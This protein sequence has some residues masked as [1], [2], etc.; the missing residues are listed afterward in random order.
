MPT[1]PTDSLRNVVLL[2]HSGAG[3]TMLAEAML[4]GGGATNRFGSIEDGTTT[5][6]YEDEEVKRQTSVQLSLLRSPWKNHTVNL[7]D[8][9]GYADFHGEVISSLRVADG[10]IVVVAASAGVEVGTQ[11]IWRMAEERNLP[12]LVFINKMDRD[13]ADFQ[14]AMDSLTESF[15]R[16]CVA[17]N[18]AIGAEASFSGIVNVLDDGADVPDEL[19]EALASAREALIEAVAETDEELTMKYLEGETLTEAEIDGGLRK[20]VKSGAIIPVLVGSATRQVGIKELMDAIVDLLPSPAGSPAVTAK[21]SSADEEVSL[22]HDANGPLAA[23]VFKTSADPFVGKL[24]Y[25]RVY[26]GTLKSDSQLWNAS[27][28][29]AERV[30]QLFVLTGKDQENVDELAPGDIGAIAKLSSVVTGD[31]MSTRDDS[32]VLAPL[33][34]PTPVF[35][36]AVYP[37]SKADLDKMTSALARIEEEDP[38]LRVTREQNTLELLLG[39]FGDVHLDVATEKMKRKFGVEIELRRPVVPYKETV[40]GATKVE[41]RH[42]K[43]TGGHGQ[44]GHVWLEIQPLPRGTGFEFDQKVVGGSVPREYIPS[45][46]KGVRGALTGGVIAGFPLVDLKATLVDGSSHPVDSS[47]VSFEIAGGHALSKGIQEA[48]PV[49]LEPIIRA[50]IVVPDNYAGDIIGDLNSKRGKILGM[51]PRGDGTTTVE[52]EAPQSEMMRYAA[53][54]RSQTQGQGWFTTEFDHYEEV[55]GHLVERVVLDIQEREK[56]REEARV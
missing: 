26:N 15:G 55:P 50:E 19:S 33:E 7:I 25:L 52:A 5:S 44:F 51:S 42:K 30:G 13:N 54:L 28:G 38:S 39:G 10:A 20:G 31:T 3:K 36:T 48:S 9:P 1:T 40:A 34:F 18:L 2:S 29:E 8:T 49:L 37:K 53:D 41:Y 16:K 4:L 45:V 12:R 32:L 24:S 17:L 47:G 27:K 6:D 11:Q 14:R 23:L 35:Q 46:E 43:Q 56:E 21:S 22:S